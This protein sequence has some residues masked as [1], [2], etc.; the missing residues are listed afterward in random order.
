MNVTLTVSSHP[1]STVFAFRVK[2]NPQ[3]VNK[4]VQSVVDQTVEQMLN[5]MPELGPRWRHYDVMNGISEWNFHSVACSHGTV[6]IQSW[7]QHDSHEQMSHR[8]AQPCTTGALSGSNG[9]RPA[10]QLAGLCT[11]P[12]G[13]DH[14]AETWV[15]KEY[16]E[17]W[18]DKYD[19]YWDTGTEQTRHIGTLCVT[20]NISHSMNTYTDTLGSSVQLW[21]I[22]YCRTLNFGGPQFLWFNLLHYFGA[23]NFCV[24]DCF[25]VMCKILF[26][27]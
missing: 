5:G 10:R 15:S 7:H 21:Y 14:R 1:I 12:V 17:L 22:M 4:L 8:E 19:W 18:W 16:V 13:N 3:F 2:H 11:I 20:V 24:F 9:L 26:S 27:K 23:I 6:V 25:P